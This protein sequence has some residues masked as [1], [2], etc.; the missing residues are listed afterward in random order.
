MVKLII[1]VFK[2]VVRVGKFILSLFNKAK[3]ILSIK[4]HITSLKKINSLY[5]KI[6]ATLK[7]NEVDYLV[8]LLQKTL[9]KIKKMNK[10]ETF[11]NNS[12]EDKKLLKTMETNLKEV[13]LK[14][15]AI[16]KALENKVKKLGPELLAKQDEV[17]ELIEL[18]NEL[19]DSKELK[20]QK[21]APKTPLCNVVS[22]DWIYSIC[23]VPKTPQFGYIETTVKK[24]MKTYRSRRL[25]PKKLIDI[26]WRTKRTKRRYFPNGRYWNNGAGNYLWQFAKLNGIGVLQ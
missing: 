26:A 24:T 11:D 18:V 25:R 23:Y 14:E 21:E 4:K 19:N 1:S 10:N 5:N 8:S 6:F 2:F 3:A 15:N 17:G 16:E 13:E 9:D 20:S 12:K 22:S 7:I